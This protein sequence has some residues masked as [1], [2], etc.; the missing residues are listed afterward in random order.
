[1][2]GHDTCP[3]CAE[4]DCCSTLPLP[5]VHSRLPKLDHDQPDYLI[6]ETIYIN[7]PGNT[8]ALRHM[9]NPILD[10]SSPNCYSSSLGNLD[11]HYSSGVANH[12][13]YHGSSCQTHSID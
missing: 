2:F 11:V 13:F 5:R 1:L 12:F 9:Y 3:Y 4:P 8:K 10:G 7:N 6:G